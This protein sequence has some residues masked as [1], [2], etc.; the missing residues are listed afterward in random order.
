M[1]ML[2]APIKH[3][4]EAAGPFVRGLASVERG[5]DFA[6]SMHDESQGAF[7]P[8]A[9][10]GNE[11][12]L[13]FNDVRLQYPDAADWALRGVTLSIQ[14][15]QT[16]AFVGT[17]GSGK[18][19][20]MNLLPR[21]IDSTSGSILL[22]GVNIQDWDLT[23]LRKQFAYVS[24]EVVM[25][26]DTLAANVALGDAAPSSN[27][28]RQALDAAYLSDLVQSLPDGIHTVVGHNAA[29]LSGGQRQR[30]AI[31]RAVYKNAPIL[32]LDEATSALD[33]ESER[34]VQQALAELMRNRTT[35]VVA[36]RLTT[37]QKA[38]CIVVM[39]EG[40]IVEAGQHATLL[41]NNA[42]YS[43]LYKTISI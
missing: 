38:D 34:A 9:Q 43:K 15:G 36:H 1:L 37:T 4:T 10:S 13:Q 33:N 21:F 42:S 16:I 5:I 40:V 17:S 23:E 39:E 27:R 2:V 28:I 31:A 30:L 35:L 26:N 6:E 41:R 29:Q 20:L 24:Q 18:T 14:K 8:S 25:F 22:G 7:A 19:S 12:L 11:F 3:L 32:L